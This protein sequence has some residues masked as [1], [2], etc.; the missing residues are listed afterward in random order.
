MKSGKEKSPAVNGACV[1]VCDNQSINRHNG[2]Q[3]IS[4]TEMN[5]AA[6][7]AGFPAQWYPHAKRC[8]Q[9]LRIGNLAGDPGA[10]LWICLRTGAWKDHASGDSGGDLISLY[11]ARENIG[12]NEAK[13]R[14]SEFLGGSGQV[15]FK[16][17]CPKKS[18]NGKRALE[19]WKASGPVPETQAERYLRSRG[20][21]HFPQSLRFHS[22]AYH[23]PT[24]KSYPAM[25]AA[26]AR[27]PEKTPHAVHRTFLADDQ[28]AEIDPNR[29]MLGEIGGGAVRLAPVHDVLAVAEGIETALSFQQMTGIPTWAVLSASNYIGLILPPSVK[30]ITVAADHDDRGIQAAHEAAE[31]WSWQGCAARVT[32]PPVKGEDFN[33]MNRECRQ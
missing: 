25:I 11:A 28:K 20:I 6:L 12:Q 23:G 24:K 15:E 33:D 16:Q 17:S 4:Y 21:S 22:A 8:G 18:D 1:D 27:W 7:A 10:S 14:L 5:S 19:L 2:K 26:I 9:S 3:E 30:E 13:Q 32:F 29:M 31:L